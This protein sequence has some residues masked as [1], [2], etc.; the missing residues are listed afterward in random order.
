LW[1]TK[2]IPYAPLYVNGRVRDNW[3]GTRVKRCPLFEEDSL[4]FREVEHAT[5]F[6]FCF[7]R[8]RVR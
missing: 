6:S 3:D 2:K 8:D 4:R 5:V 7:H 1:A